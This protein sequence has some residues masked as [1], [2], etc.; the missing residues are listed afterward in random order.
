MN[1]SPLS[2][3][4]IGLIVFFIVMLI[5]VVVANLIAY[6]PDG[7]DRRRRRVSFWTLGGLIPTATFAAGYFLYY[8]NIRVPSRAEAYM[9]ALCISAVVFYVAYIVLG[10]VLAKI[11]KHGKLS[12]WF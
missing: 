9:T 12:S 10:F 7:S 1:N 11:F 4:V 8:Q 2:A 6:A 5:S 3:Y